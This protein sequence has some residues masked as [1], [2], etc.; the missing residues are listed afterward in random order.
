M[1]L[2]AELSGTHGGHT[3]RAHYNLIAAALFLPSKG[4][5]ASIFKSLSFSLLLKV[6]KYLW[7]KQTDV[8][9]ARVQLLSL[10]LPKSV[11]SCITSKLQDFVSVI[12]FVLSMFILLKHSI[13]TNCGKRYKTSISRC[14]TILS[15]PTDLS[16]QDKSSLLLTLPV[17]F[18]PDLS[19][20]VRGKFLA[21]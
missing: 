10:L 7:K 18:I 13:L 5:Q 16:K 15:L 8:K 21:L 4:P 2:C 20:C 19:K 14:K 12:S 17:H 9:E 6:R 3:G 11:T 1:I